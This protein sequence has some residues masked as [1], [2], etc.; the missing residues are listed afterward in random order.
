MTASAYRRTVA[1]SCAAIALV[2]AGGLWW[3]G[4]AVL[5]EDVTLPLSD[6]TT[7]HIG[8]VSL[9]SG[10]A[11]V[12]PATAAENLT[13]QN[14][15][16]DAGDSTYRMARI[17]LVG[18]SLGQAQFAAILDKSN[19]EPFANRLA[20]FAATSIT[21]PEVVIER[22][23]AGRKQKIMLRDL[24]PPAPRPPA[25]PPP[26]PTADAAG[27]TIDQPGSAGTFGAVSGK[28]LDLALSARLMS[29]A[30]GTPDRAP[31]VLFT[32]FTIDA[33]A[34][35]GV[36]GDSVIGIK[37]VAMSTARVQLGDKA[38][39][40][41]PFLG[42]LKVSEASA[43]IPSVKVKGERLKWTLKEFSLT[44]DEP[45]DGI[46]TKFSAALADLALELPATST[47]ATF[48]NLIDLG[49]SGLVFSVAAEG[50]WNTQA[51][52]FMV[53]QVSLTGADIGAIVLRGTF[54]KVTKDVFSAN[55]TVA[56]AAFQGATAKTMSI[57]IENKGL[58]EHAVMREAKKRGKSLED[59]RRE[60]GL[61]AV[62]TV[63]AMMGDTPDAKALGS[64]VAK[65]AAKPG[66]LTVSAKAK[67]AAGVP[68]AE[69]G[70]AGMRPTIAGKLEVTATAE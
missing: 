24:V 65:F 2:A 13:L 68:L 53:R 15:T 45:R 38:T 51:S 17:E 42:T 21:M 35:K 66:R 67:A 41:P 27:G 44:A 6:G 28:T 50:N 36:V 61:A 10:F 63:G 30:A 4:D 14:V 9:A 59:T 25:P 55:G 46:P 43:D 60:I 64:A 1:G 56:H 34:F 58:Y 22:L 7:I 3:A 62:M 37:R 12:T 8:R 33:L 40:F 54:G 23:S 39:L 48:K 32:S 47:D 49:Y 57:A 69:F 20:S 19:R 29:E 11:L 16:V 70:D 31:R 5:V 18:S 26:P 52:E